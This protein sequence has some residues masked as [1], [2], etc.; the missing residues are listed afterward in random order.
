MSAEGGINPF[1]CFGSDI[2]LSIATF[3]ATTGTSMLV[4]SAVWIEVAIAVVRCQECSGG[5]KL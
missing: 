1:D 5:A 3:G 2:L 4:E